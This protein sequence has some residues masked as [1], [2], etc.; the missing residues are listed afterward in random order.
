MCLLISTTSVRWLTLDW[1]F[2]LSNTDMAMLK[3]YIS[4]KQAYHGWTSL[5][6]IIAITSLLLWST[7]LLKLIKEIISST[8]C[9]C[10]WYAS[11]KTSLDTKQKKIQTTSDTQVKLLHNSSLNDFFT[12]LHSSKVDGTW[13]SV[14]KDWRTLSTKWCV[15]IKNGFRLYPITQV[16]RLMNNSTA[17]NTGNHNS[18][19]S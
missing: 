13:N 12:G 14:W 19:W 2:R 4:Y 8:A 17:Y 11:V 16:F 9:V 1:H 18:L 5:P 15:C 6:C 3:R 7:Y 10:V